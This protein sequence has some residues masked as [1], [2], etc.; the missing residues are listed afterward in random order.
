MMVESLGSCVASGSK[1]NVWAN[2]DMSS[3]SFTTWILNAGTWT[4]SSDSVTMSM[5]NFGHGVLDED[6]TEGSEPTLPALPTA[7][8]YSTTLVLAKEW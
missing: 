7:L 2:S 1:I 6:D 4:W 5:E 8:T 3:T